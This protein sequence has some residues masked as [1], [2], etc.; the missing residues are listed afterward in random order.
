MLTDT[1]KLDTILLALDSQKKSEQWQNPVHIPHPSTWLNQHRW[2]D[3]IPEPIY[4]NRKQATPAK[5]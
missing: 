5:W 3:V 4:G 2:E 1:V